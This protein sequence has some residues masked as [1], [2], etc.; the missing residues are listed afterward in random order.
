MVIQVHDDSMLLQSGA[1][2]VQAMTMALTACLVPPLA[3]LN[4]HKPS[5][6]MCTQ[7]SLTRIAAMALGL[8]VLDVS[9]MILL[10]TRPWFQGGTGNAY[11]V[12]VIP[13]HSVYAACV[14]VLVRV[15]MRACVQ[16]LYCAYVCAHVVN[17]ALTNQ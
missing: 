13:Q 6:R 8:E 2:D 5:G 17:A 4:P 3:R 11:M 9:Y 12:H 10:S 7:A 16:Q 1:I 14:C 15:C